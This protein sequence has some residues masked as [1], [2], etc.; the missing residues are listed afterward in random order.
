MNIP[1][2]EQF[3]AL[4]KRVDMH[5][6]EIQLLQIQLDNY[7]KRYQLFFDE[8][9]EHFNPSTIRKLKELDEKYD[10]KTE[11]VQLKVVK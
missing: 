8:L 2:N 10:D 5:K 6:L 7:Q 9:K 11:T 1:T 4:I 3:N